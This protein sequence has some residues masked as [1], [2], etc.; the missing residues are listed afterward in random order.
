MMN[1]RMVDGLDGVVFPGE[2]GK[3]GFS[4]LV[5][6]I[7]AFRMNGIVNDH[8]QLTSINHWSHDGLVIEKHGPSW[9]IMATRI[10][11]SD[12]CGLLS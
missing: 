1:F 9:D 6:F 7:L 4:L 11:D 2:D 8:L 10:V 3:Y 12:A 5:L